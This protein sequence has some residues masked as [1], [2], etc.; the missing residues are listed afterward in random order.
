MRYFLSWVMGLTILTGFSAAAFARDASGW[1]GTW[2]A[3][4]AGLPPTAKLGA[5]TLPPRST[6]KGTVRY[7]LRI[8]RGGRQVRLRFSNEY[9][10]RPITLN[11]VTV[12][13][14][15][16]SLNA[17]PGS[18]RPVTFGGKETITVPA[19]APV[20][21]DP[22]ALEVGDFA[23]LVVSVYLNDGTTVFD[24]G[25]D[26]APADQAVV[27]GSDATL[28]EH[29]SAGHCLFTLRPLIS[30]IDVLAYNPRKVIVTL[31][32]SITD[33]AVDDQTGERGWPDALSRRLHGTGVSVVNA[34]IGGNRLLQSLPGFGASALSRLDR[35]VL[36]VPG[37]T[38]IV[39]LE[40]INDIRMSGPEGVFGSTPSVSPEDLI[41]AYRQL[42]ARA[43]ERGTKLI[44]ATLTPFGGA[45]FYTAEREKTRTSIND[46]IRATKELDA[47]I[48]FDADLRDPVN[49]AR[50]K[51]EYDSGD[52]L[53]P[54]AAGY[55]RM[56]GMIDVGVFK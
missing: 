13:L 34:G 23:D 38:H 32:D 12:G 41:W 54:N 5:L 42:V 2:Q 49:R 18:L 26:A 22:M 36:S 35:D 19:G 56:G 14:A 40:G 16:E 28:A 9:G 46:W 7:R 51:P 43:H 33:G 29:F 8:S 47:V 24:C 4:P 15:S 48:D 55:R 21:S 11:A 6:V 3:S 45:R 44:G 52:H 50:L 37:L 17:A 30:G 20:L 25:S 31:G 27:D 39:V 1:I 10:D 53:H